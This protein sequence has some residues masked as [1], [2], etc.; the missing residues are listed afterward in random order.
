M[1]LFSHQSE[2]RLRTCHPALQRILREG[3][4]HADFSVLEGHRN[5]ERQN[6]LFEMGQSKLRWPHGK[7]NKTPSEAVDVG[8][9]PL[10]WKKTDRFIRILSFLQGIGY[11]MGIP[12]RIGGDWNSDFLFNE[13]WYDWPHLELL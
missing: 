6:Y 7:H 5:Q 2:E 9:H 8:P 4:K 12:V 11:G 13:S 1:P 3:I 10:D